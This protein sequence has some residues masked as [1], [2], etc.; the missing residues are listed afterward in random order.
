MA[1]RLEQL[2]QKK[3]QL[4]LQIKSA[5]EKELSKNRKEDT[6]RRLLIGSA[7]LQM[8]EKDETLKQWLE[9]LLDDYLERKNDRLLFD[10]PLR[11][12]HPSD[13]NSQGEVADDFKEETPDAID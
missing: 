9:E 6:R 7:L 11:D 8:T 1:S 10:L 13:G 3:A 4:E 12:N 5:Q 2:R